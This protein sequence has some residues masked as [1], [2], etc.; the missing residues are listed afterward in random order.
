MRPI[1]NRVM[2]GGGRDG[3]CGEYFACG[4]VRRPPPLP[5]PAWQAG[6]QP[7][8]HKHTYSD[9]LTARVQPSLERQWDRYGGWVYKSLYIYF[10]G[11]CC[12][13]VNVVRLNVAFGYMSFSLRSFGLMSFGVM[14]FGLLSVYQNFLRLFRIVY[15][16]LYFILQFF[17]WLSTIFW[18]TK[19]LQ[20]ISVG[21][22][23][24]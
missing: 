4:P 17:G 22:K 19:C 15:Y 5:L 24:K 3:V 12:F 16:C 14:P 9:E 7:T 11:L 2:G 23:N 21:S 10:S 13:R 20:L 18:K 1:L 8:P 6:T